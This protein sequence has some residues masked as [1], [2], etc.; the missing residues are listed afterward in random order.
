MFATYRKQEG[1]GSN[2]KRFTMG[3]GSIREVNS[4]GRFRSIFQELA[5]VRLFT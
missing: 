2:L 1:A 3:T 5:A 4:L